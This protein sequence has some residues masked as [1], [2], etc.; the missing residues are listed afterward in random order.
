[1]A[2]MSNKPHLVKFCL[3][4][5]K[6]KLGQNKSHLQ[7]LT[8][9]RPKARYFASFPLGNYYEKNHYFE[10]QITVLVTIFAKKIA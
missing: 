6:P 5:L 3:R 8:K 1:M 10:K 4:L 7:G 2:V 9:F